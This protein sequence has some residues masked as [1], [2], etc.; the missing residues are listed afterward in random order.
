[1][2][3]LTKI[4]FVTD[5]ILLN[6]YA[7]DPKLSS[8][9]IVIIDE[10]HERRV[11]TDLLFGVMK[12][13]LRQRD[14][15]KV[16]LYFSHLSFFVLSI[17][18]SSLLCRLHWTL[19]CFVITIENHVYLKYLGVRIRLKMSLPMMMWKNMSNQQ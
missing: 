6:Q 19:I 15:I 7:E 9:S 10:A 12:L 16:C 14:D 17:S 5:T 2:S 11:D 3:Y 18:H 13:C 4:R 1:M 8:Y